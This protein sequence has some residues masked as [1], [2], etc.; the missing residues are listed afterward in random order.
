MIK[1]DLTFVACTK[2]FMD[3]YD[4]YSLV[5]NHLNFEK[6]KALAFEIIM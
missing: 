4:E 6:D 5:K 2:S 3:H 1:N